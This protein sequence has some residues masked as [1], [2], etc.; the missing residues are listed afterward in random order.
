MS[1]DQRQRGA[2]GGVVEEG[3]D[4]PRAAR[5]RRAKAAAPRTTHTSASPSSS[6]THRQGSGGEVAAVEGA[7]RRKSPGR[8]VVCGGGRG[9]AHLDIGGSARRGRR[10]RACAGMMCISFL[11]AS[12]PAAPLVGGV[13]RV[14]GL[15]ASPSPTRRRRRG[16]PP[17]PP[18]PGGGREIV[19]SDRLLA[20]RAPPP[21][22]PAP[23]SARAPPPPAA[24]ARPRLLQRDLGGHSTAASA[25]SCVASGGR[26]V[27]A[28]FLREALAAHP[29]CAWRR[30]PSRLSP[31]PRRDD[32]PPR[33]AFWR[34]S[35]STACNPRS[36]GAGPS[37]SGGRTT[38]R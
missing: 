7:F 21:P 19:G 32:A 25:S 28:R 36:S 6:C 35:R 8:K 10:H 38:R 33:R 12:A 5:A 3:A 24:S 23:P 16:P 11:A 14:L 18:Q 34:T 26:F 22:P 17:S 2:D 29:D 9:D 15:P 1:V 20:A 37:A 13:A 31:P 27:V 30:T 4:A